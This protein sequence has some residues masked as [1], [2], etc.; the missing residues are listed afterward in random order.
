VVQH[1]FA[2]S[3]SFTSVTRYHPDAPLLIFDDGIPEGMHVNFIDFA[4]LYYHAKLF[5]LHL[6][7]QCAVII[8][9]RSVVPA[10]EGYI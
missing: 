1:L 3:Y 10:I 7:L 5:V 8:G 4:K 2:L 9:A 6:A